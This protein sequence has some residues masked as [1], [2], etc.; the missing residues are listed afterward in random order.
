MLPDTGTQMPRYGNEGGSTDGVENETGTGSGD[1]IISA[2]QQALLRFR[3]SSRGVISGIAQHV[4]DDRRSRRRSRH[5]RRASSPEW[6]PRSSTPTR[7]SPFTG[8]PQYLRTSTLTPP[9][10][11]TVNIGPYTA[12]T[13][14][15]LPRTTAP[16]PKLILVSLPPTNPKANPR[17]CKFGIDRLL[18]RIESIFSV[19]I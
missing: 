1:A 5:R 18:K 13:L 3:P 8:P 17:R 2:Q 19:G 15:S 11:E 9:R 12:P 6:R 16:L 4:L 14:V 10:E 7:I